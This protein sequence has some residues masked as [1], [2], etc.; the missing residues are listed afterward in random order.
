MG[1][2]STARPGY[3]RAM[4]DERDATYAKVRASFGPHAAAYTTSKGHAD[5]ALLGELVALVAPRPTDRVLDVGTGAGHTGLAFAPRV[6]SVVALDATPEMLTEV[7]RNAEARGLANVRTHHGTAEALP[8][9][10][11]SF[12]LVVTRLASHHFADLATAVRETARVLVAGGRLLVTD[13]AVPEDPDLD[14]EINA[15]EL[16]RDPAHVRNCRPSEWRTML[17]SAGLAVTYLE[18]GYYDEGA[19]MDFD[20]WVRRI[21][22]AAPAVEELRR[23]F[24]TARPALAESLRVRCVGDAI[25]FELPRITLVAT[26]PAA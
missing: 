1:V 6:A 9:P 18:T 13:T 17:A 12:E 14:R 16:L 22:T 7:A 10:D 5:A 23:R 8:F 4:T 20:A 15:I 11:A 26:K 25:A 2:F 24:R 21:G 19:G 3:G